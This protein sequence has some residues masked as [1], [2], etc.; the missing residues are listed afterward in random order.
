MAGAS[1]NRLPSGERTRTGTAHLILI[2]KLLPKDPVFGEEQ[3]H[4]TPQSGRTQIRTADLV[5]IRDA[6]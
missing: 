6:L 1:T 3:R 4:F 2:R 5:L